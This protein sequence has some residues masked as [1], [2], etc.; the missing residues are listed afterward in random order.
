M[1]IVVTRLDENFPD[2]DMTEKWNNLRPDPI[3]L[4]IDEIIQKCREQSERASWQPVAEGSGT[5]HDPGIAIP[6]DLMWIDM[7]L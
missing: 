6:M 4:E 1:V 2:V 5:Q 3:M 7:L